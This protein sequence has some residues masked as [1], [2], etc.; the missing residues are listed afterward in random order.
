MCYWCHFPG[1]FDADCDAPHQECRT[2]ACRVPPGHAYF[3]TLEDCPNSKEWRGYRYGMKPVGGARVPQPEQAKEGKST[4]QPTIVAS[5]QGARII[6]NAPG[7]N[8]VF[9]APTIEDY[10]GN[11]QK[12]LA[13]LHEEVPALPAPPSAMSTSVAPPMSEPLR[14][15]SPLTPLASP[16][17][18]LKQVTQASASTL[19]K[20]SQGCR[21]PSLRGQKPYVKA[22]MPKA[23]Q[24]ITEQEADE[25]CQGASQVEMHYDLD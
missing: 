5:P 21:I 24:E 4:F 18:L 10:L 13:V 8:L 2:I 19:P 3:N 6:A 11:L 1:H 23:T 16:E 25:I 9:H 15:L 17:P 20:A 14:S 7:Q 12:E 22:K